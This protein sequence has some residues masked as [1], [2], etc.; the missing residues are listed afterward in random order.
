MSYVSPPDVA[1]DMLEQGTSKA[2]LS[3]FQQL[4]RSTF[5]VFILGGATAMAIQATE[6]TGIGLVGALVFPLGLT[7]VVLLSMELLTGNFALVPLAVLEGR[8]KLSGLLRSF[9]WVLAGHVIGGLLCAALFAA[10]LTEFWTIDSGLLLNGFIESAEENTLRYQQ[11]GAVAGIGLALLSGILCNWLVVLGVVM[12]M[13]STS[14]TG[15]IMALWLPIAA[16]FYL[17]LEHAVVNLFVI[18]A[19]MFMGAD[20]SIADWWIWNQIPV[21]IGNL[22]GGLVLLG[23]PVYLAYRQ[24]Q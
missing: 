17:G 8:A 18:P 11:M 6:E 19:G 9:G 20:V 22:I 15:K 3:T 24:K 2:E 14:T 12:G 13:T 16:F 4:L 21:L 5:A 7:V 23:L 10:L 1:E